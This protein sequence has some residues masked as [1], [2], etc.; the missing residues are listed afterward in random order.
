M[1]AN[2][3]VSMVLDECGTSLGK[4]DAIEQMLTVGRGYGLKMLLIFQSMAQIK[5]VFGE[6]NEGVLLANTSQLFFG[7]RDKD[8]AE[9]VSAVI[10][11]ETVTVHG[12]GA[13]RGWSSQ[14]GEGK[15][16]TSYSGG[17]STSWGLQA[18]RLLKPEE[19]LTM[20][21]RAVICLHKGVP[22]IYARLVRYDEGFGEK[23]IGW[24]KCAFNTVLMFGVALGFAVM[25]S[26]MAR[27]TFK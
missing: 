7:I 5:K 13:N 24:L 6:N 22:P 11:D 17:T 14:S 4:L 26:V 2:R 19:L 1:G 15:P 23:K 10:G 8:T 3:P 12:G 21:E 27:N 9:Y 20:P 25:M 18:R 16:T